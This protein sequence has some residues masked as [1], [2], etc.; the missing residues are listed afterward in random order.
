MTVFRQVIRGKLNASEE[1]IPREKDRQLVPLL[2][3]VRRHKVRAIVRGD[4][5][6]IF[7]SSLKWLKSVNPGLQRSF[8]KEGQGARFAHRQQEFKWLRISDFGA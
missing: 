2:L 5:E 6:V 4:I 7:G 8:S 3:L 1:V